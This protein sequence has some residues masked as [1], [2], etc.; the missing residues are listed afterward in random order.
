MKNNILKIQSDIISWPPNY[1]IKK[2]ASARQI[3]LK[4]SSR[5]GLE[6]IVPTRFNL[7][8]IPKIL[9]ENRKWIEKQF[10]QLQQKRSIQENQTLPNKIVLSA[11]NQ[12]WDIHYIESSAKMKIITRPHQEIVL[13]GKIKNKILC[14]KLLIAW[15]KHHAKIHLAEKLK[16][17]SDMTKLSYSKITIRDQKTRW[18]SCTKNKSI[19]L[20]FKILFLPSHLATHILIHE[21]CHTVHLNHSEKFWQLVLK[22]DPDCQQHRHAVRRVDEF[23]PEWIRDC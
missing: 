18:G 4:I 10:S 2:H 15:L 12:S 9:L 5:K 22:F 6:L 21:L 3:K 8:Y 13:L 7:K 11:I 23:I 1:A 17:V 14:K 20:N 19:N 16:S